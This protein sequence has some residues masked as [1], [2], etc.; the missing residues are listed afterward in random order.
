MPEFS[1]VPFYAEFAD[2]LAT[3]RDRQASL[4]E[5]LNA[6]RAA[7]RTVTPLVDRDAQNREV[8]V[9][10]LD[11]FT[12]FGTFNR[13]TKTSNRI[14]LLDAIK[15]E[16]RVAAPVPSDFA[17]VP[18]LHPLNSW[19]FDYA[20]KR[21]AGV[22]DNLWD[23]FTEALKPGALE[24]DAFGGAFDRA[25]A[26]SQVGL[27]LTLG[28]YWIR[29]E[30]FLNLDG[31][32][33][34]YLGFEVNTDT[35]TIGEYRR[36]ISQ[37]RSMGRP[38]YRIS[39]EAFVR[40]GETEKAAAVPVADSQ[41]CWL[42]GAYWN[43][44]D[45]PDQTADF[46]QRGVWVN[47]YTDKYIDQVRQMR[48]GDRIAIK[49]T[50]VQRHNLPF[51]Y[52]KTVSKM[53][54]KARG[55]IRRNLNDGR[56][57]EVDWDPNFEA[58]EWYFYTFRGTVWKL[59]LSSECA[60]LLIDFIFRDHPQDYAFFVSL[61]TKEFPPEGKEGTSDDEPIE[62]AITDAAELRE[63][64]FLDPE[65][66]D[67]LLERL[68]AKRNLIL[69]GAP[70]VGKTFIARRL[71]YALFGARDDSRVQT[72][73]F[74]QSYAYEDF[75]QGFRPSVSAA[76]TLTFTLRNGVFYEFCLQAQKSDAEHVFIIDEI[77]R[78]NVSRIFGELL[79]LIEAD[80]R[81]E[82][83][84]L[85]LAYQQPD[86]PHFW[87]PDNV[88]ILGL[89]NLADR[90]L[91]MVDYA[92]RRRFAF[93]TLR[94]K[95]GSARFREWLR[96]R[97]MSDTLV[98]RITARIGALNDRIAKDRQLGPHFEIGHS[99]FCPTG[100]DVSGFGDDWYRAVVETQIGPL[101]EEYWHDDPETAANE[102]RRL[103]ER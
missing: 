93:V 61:W 102:T 46:I 24:G 4:I 59:D 92:L 28:L 16:F 42:V 78:G 98:D 18:I 73:Q 6:Q 13:R 32:M 21:K 8:P 84:A 19:F 48:R 51:P 66:F 99:Y 96:K 76:S 69:Q 89:M 87:V 97:G 91:A 95:F 26:L 15:T 79:M 82:A 30:V 86:D 11:P 83:H 56:T 75:V 81:A 40:R 37:V 72:V 88:H 3:F 50:S 77:N 33:R 43:T 65:E 64:L 23:V 7:G 58:R 90:S 103:I 41:S 100:D 47:G 53:S 29:P 5:F 57:V 39:Q 36:L 31:P 17:G 70:G 60:R 34:E 80:K 38:I 49:S 2:R 62:G 27:K 35:L 12:F 63:G 71:A 10:V 22:I 52:D 9:T 85:R 101:L 74:H 14:A 1:W 44:A 25:V 20:P 45:V 54:I 55:T 94:P 68:R 67:V